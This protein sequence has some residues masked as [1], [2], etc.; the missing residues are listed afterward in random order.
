V[1]EE[2]HILE[3]LHSSTRLQPPSF[4]RIVPFENTS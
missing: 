2:G 4:T 1:Y 3:E